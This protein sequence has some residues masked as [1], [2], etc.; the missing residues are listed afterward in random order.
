MESPEYDE[1]TGDQSNDTIILEIECDHTISATGLTVDSQ[2]V[3]CFIEDIDPD[4]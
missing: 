3:F 2:R 4:S 1:I